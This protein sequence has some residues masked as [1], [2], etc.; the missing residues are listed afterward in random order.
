MDIA[1]VVKS[2][3]HCAFSCMHQMYGI[4]MMSTSATF[5]KLCTRLQCGQRLFSASSTINVGITHTCPVIVDSWQPVCLSLVWTQTDFLFGKS[6]C[7]WYPLF[8]HP[9]IYLC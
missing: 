8:M 7:A 6:N 5:Y 2:A 9:C 4:D 1:I 3:C